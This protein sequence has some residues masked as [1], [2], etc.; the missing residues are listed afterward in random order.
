MGQGPY[1]LTALDG[2]V[3]VLPD[4]DSDE[5]ARALH[6]AIGPTDLRIRIESGARWWN[7][8]S[9]GRSTLHIERLPGHI[10]RAVR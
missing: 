2:L 8:A 5:G 10:Y 1:L 9:W 6:D 7:P 3:G 4:I